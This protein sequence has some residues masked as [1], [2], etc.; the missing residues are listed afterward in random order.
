MIYKDKQRFLNFSYG[1]FDPKPVSTFTST[2]YLGLG[3][4]PDMDDSIL[5]WAYNLLVSENP[6]K[7]PYY[8]Q[9]VCEI[10]EERKSDSLGELVGTEKSKGKFHSFYLFLDYCVTICLHTDDILINYI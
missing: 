1:P 2:C 9:A 8:L 5:I 4:L 7:N 3:C 6:E 10:Y